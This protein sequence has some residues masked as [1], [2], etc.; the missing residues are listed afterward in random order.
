[1]S[2]PTPSALQSVSDSSEAAACP[3]CGLLCDDVVVATRPAIAVTDKGC[4]R[5]RAMFAQQSRVH[6]AIGPSIEG[7]AVT[8]DQAVE[9]AAQLL[10]NKVQPLLLNA[11]TDVAGMRALIELAE[12]IG[13]VIDHVNSDALLRNLRVLQDTGWMATTLSEVRNRCDLLIVAG[14]NVLQRFPRLF[15]RS[16]EQDAMFGAIEREMVFMGLGDS[17]PAVRV[18]SSA[19]AVEP[20]RL[21]EV[22]AALRALLAGRRLLID[23][24]AGVPLADLTTLLER[25]RAAR[26]GVLTWAAADL[27]FPHAELAVQSMCELVQELNRTTR[28]VCLPLGGN[29]GDLTAMQVSTWQTG[30]PLR[31]SFASG[32]P[33]FDPH[34]YSPQQL[35]ADGEADALVF[36]SALDSERMPPAINVPAIVLS[37]PGPAATDAT[38]H[39]PIGTP[40]LHHA[41]HLFRTDNV[42]AVRAPQRLRSALPSAASVLSQILQRTA[43]HS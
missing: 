40:G 39:F 25:M 41:G 34:R 1:M 17:P 43:A 31:V 19:I 28:F 30:Y 11:G 7:K 5:S 27:D 36:L 8:L 14:S 26:Y 4:A 24:V 38:V 32:A 23:T 22:F 2:S 35:L 15:E 10:A 37:P 33:V 29:D 9:R 13:G 3:F 16:L 18:R 20:A 12:R 6:D 42:V 21:G